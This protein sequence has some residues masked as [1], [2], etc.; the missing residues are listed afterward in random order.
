MSAS[1]FLG[2]EQRSLLPPLYSR[3]VTVS[4]ASWTELFPLLDGNNVSNPVRAPEG[5]GGGSATEKV[6]LNTDGLKL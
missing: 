6:V 3:E 2:S 1:S 4:T 5:G